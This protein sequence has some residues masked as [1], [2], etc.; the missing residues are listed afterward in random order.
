MIAEEVMISDVYK[1]NQKD[2]IRSVINYFID[3][4]ISGLPVINDE[5]KIVGYISDGDIMR[6]IGKHKDIFVDSLYNVTVFK[7]DKEDFEARI[8]HV[9]D[10]NVMKLAKKKIVK[11]DVTAH[12]E[13]VAAILGKKQIK[14]LPVEKDEKLVGII[15]RGDV[16]RHA[17]QRFL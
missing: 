5:E 1:V 13:N 6:Y 17:F 2:T 16:I 8:Q 3:Y 9:L 4:R 12:I 14:K 7:G 11:V 15:S 10:L